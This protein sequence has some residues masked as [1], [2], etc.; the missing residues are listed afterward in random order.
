MD[1]TKLIENFLFNIMFIM[2]ILLIYVIFGF[3][4]TTILILSF[5]YLN[6][7]TKSE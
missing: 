6:I 7:R 2:S 1:W 4:I 5:I 3:D